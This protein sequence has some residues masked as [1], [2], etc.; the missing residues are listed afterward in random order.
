MAAAP[1]VTG[2][3]QRGAA[4]IEIELDG[5]SWRVVPLVALQQ[6]ALAVGSALDRGAARELGRA[7]RR[8]RALSVAV[9]AL[10]GRDHTTASLARRL[11]ARGV[12]PAER[13]ETLAVLGRAGLVDDT[14]FAHDR[15]ALLARRGGG[16][17]RIAFDLERQGVAAE[18]AAA[19][20][21]ALEPE[22]E[23]A[24]RIVDERGRTAK[25]LRALAAQGFSEEALEG[26]V[27]EADA[28]ALG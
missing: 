8:H 28:G 11:A 22:R 15:A 24:Q 19:A 1:R 6:T 23:R 9:G 3:R 4:R 27:A 10:R 13:S 14:R 26:L 7:L 21:A 20:I 5:A 18:L 25:T 2:L 12:R 17:R 16:D